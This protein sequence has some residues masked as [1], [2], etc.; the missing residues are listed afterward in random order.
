MTN[1]TV[2]V[3]YNVAP[4][5]KEVIKVEVTAWSKAEAKKIVKTRFS[6]IYFGVRIL[7]C[8]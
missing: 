5:T 2:T 3:A 6:K 1:Y 8:V 7:N 4:L